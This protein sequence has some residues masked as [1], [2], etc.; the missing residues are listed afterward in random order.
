MIKNFFLSTWR[1]LTRYKSVSLLN[2]FGLSAGMTAAVLIFLW[3]QNELSYDNFHPDVGRIYR[4]TSYIS[5]AK[6]TWESTPYPLAWRVRSEIPEVE[7]VTRIQET[8]SVF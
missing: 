6:W 8:S 7:S 5:S 2:I 1:T 4:I 3:V